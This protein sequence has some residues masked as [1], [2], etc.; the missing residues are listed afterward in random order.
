MLVCNATRLRLVLNDVC[1]AQSSA[2]YIHLQKVPMLNSFCT[3]HKA[4]PSDL[5]EQDIVEVEHVCN[6]AVCSLNFGIQL[7]A[8]VGHI[9]D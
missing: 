5:T 1:V 2:L 9:A 6:V 7:P 3:G 8:Y 4:Q